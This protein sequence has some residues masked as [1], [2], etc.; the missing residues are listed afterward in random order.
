LRSQPA[1]G[2]E[3]GVKWADV[4]HRV[5]DNIN[6]KPNPSVFGPPDRVE[7]NKIQEFKVLQRNAENFAH[8]DRNRVRMQNAIQEAG[9]FREPIDHGGRSFKPQYGP[10]KPFQMWTANLCTTQGTPQPWKE[11]RTVR[12]RPR[13]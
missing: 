11:A 8:D 2:K 13:S 12:I 6:E 1:V 5:V 7:T 9:G 10:A 4:A 3:K